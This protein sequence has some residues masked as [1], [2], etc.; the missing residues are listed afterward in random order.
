MRKT[1]KQR[2]ITGLAGFLLFS[3]QSAVQEPSALVQEFAAIQAGSFTT[4][5]QA[6]TEPGYAVVEAEVVRI[7]PE[8]NDGLWMYQEQAILAAGEK[9]YK[10][11]KSKPYFQRVFRLLQMDDGRL[12]RENYE[13]KDPAAVVGAYTSP[14]QMNA[15][16]PEDLVL[17]G[18]ANQIERVASGYWRAHIHT[19]PNTYR[20]AT[21]MTSKSVYT[22]DTLANWD[23]GFD[24]AGNVVWGPTSGGY[25]FKR[26]TR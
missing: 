24:A 8:R 21:H 13:L 7:W 11:G 15:L 3:A 2:L 17:G 12:V 4:A 23:R 19:C 20:G 25:I 14:K 5:E 1:T 16:S 18:C 10:D 6:A 9:L 22:P 26:K